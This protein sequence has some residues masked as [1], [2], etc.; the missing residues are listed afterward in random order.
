MVLLGGIFFCIFLTGSCKFKDQYGQS[1]IDCMG[2]KYV[3]NILHHDEFAA[4]QR[5]H[6]EKCAALQKQLDDENKSQSTDGLIV[7]ISDDSGEICK[8]DV[9]CLML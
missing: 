7:T 3:Y 1:S 5:A 8:R 9:S 4:A 6:Q 2:M